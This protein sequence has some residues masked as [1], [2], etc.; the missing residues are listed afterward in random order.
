MNAIDNLREAA[1]IIR[2]PAGRDLASMDRVATWLEVLAA[3]AAEMHVAELVEIEAQPIVP[4]REIRQ[5]VHVSELLAE[6]EHNAARQF[7]AR[8]ILAQF[9]RESQFDREESHP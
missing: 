3:R 7:G 8:R 5:N 6:Y 4:R 9:L 1:Q 2:D